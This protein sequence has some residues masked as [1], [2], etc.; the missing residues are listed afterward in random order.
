M[1][2]RV[3]MVLVD[4]EGGRAFLR[5]LTVRVAVDGHVLPFVGDSRVVL[6]WAVLRVKSLSA[7]AVS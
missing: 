5:G 3:R 1:K 2:L 6:G 7:A 4:P